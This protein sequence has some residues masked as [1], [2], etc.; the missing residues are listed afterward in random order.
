MS[1]QLTLLTTAEKRRSQRREAL[2]GR[3]F[4]RAVHRFMDLWHG[5]EEA[6]EKVSIRIRVCLQA[7]RKSLKIGPAL[8]AEVAL[9]WQAMNFS[10]TSGKPC[11]LQ[12][13][14]RREFFRKL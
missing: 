10:A 12:N 4:S 9:Y 11:P 3:G 5:W 8:A 14:R 1:I 13:S 2:K 6:A 7:Y